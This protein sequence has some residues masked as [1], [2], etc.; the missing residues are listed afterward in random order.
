MKNRALAVM[1]L[2][3]PG[4]VTLQ[5]GDRT[6]IR[7]VGMARTMNASAF[8]T[9]A[10][11]INPANLAV[12]DRGSFRL[13]LSPIGFA[14]RSDLIS[15]DIYQDYFTGVPGPDGTRVAKYLTA[16]D[17]Q[18][19]LSRLPDI[20][21]TMFELEDMWLGVS[22]RH[23]VIGGIGFSITDRMGWRLTLPKDYF[24]LFQG[25]DVNG[26]TYDFSG[27]GFS[28]W[29]YREYNFSYGR[30]I[31]SPVPLVRHLYA[32]VGVKILRGYG[33]LVTDYYRSKFGNVPDPNDPLQYTLMGNSDFRELRSGID[34]FDKSKNADMKPFPDPAGKGV[35]FDLGVSA[36]ILGDI[37]ASLS[38][39]DIGKITWDRNVFETT[40][41]GAITIVDIAS[42][43]R[44]SIRDAF[45]GQDNALP[46][47]F[48]TALPTRLRLGA[49]VRSGEL[50]FLRWM[51]GN[52][53]LAMDYTQGLN[54]SLGNTTKPRF[55]LGMEYRIIPLLPLRTGI[56]LGGGDK[57]RWAAGFGL[58]FYALTLDF[59]TDNFGILFSPKNFSMASFSFGLGFRI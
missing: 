1:L 9:D 53:M 8:G 22:F 32:G 7:G 31:P 28:A 55:S 23:P 50:R 40:G 44:D 27:T 10:L 49:M 47:S 11:G 35:G 38:V 4:V 46:G 57:F 36:N 20:G 58:D 5:A 15:Y 42:A 18:D 39:T 17:Q 21:S 6:N 24:R 56:S 30:E 12:Y 2:V 19:I 45:A 52:M 26:T 29:W 3:L 16:A 48:T 43:A 13:V 37:H 14:V 34:V 25:L 51:P 33:A 41:R 54:Q 59:A